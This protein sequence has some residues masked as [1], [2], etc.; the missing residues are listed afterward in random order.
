M[1][2]INI[3]LALSLSLPIYAQSSNEQPVE[4]SR[5]HKIDVA[6]GATGLGLAALFLTASILKTKNMHKKV[7]DIINAPDDHY[8]TVRQ[9]VDSAK[10]TWQFIRNY[11]TF[12][13]NLKK[14]YRSGDFAIDCEKQRI[15]NDFYIIPASF[16]TSLISAGIGTW[17][18]AHYIAHVVKQRKE[19]QNKE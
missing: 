3:A 11:P 6:I 16:I 14:N 12:R 5:N 10:N 4:K 13:S 18:S 7:V 15:S 1:K 9:P 2:K 17:Y 19:K 8:K